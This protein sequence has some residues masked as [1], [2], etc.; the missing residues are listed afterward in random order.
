MARAWWLHVNSAHVPNKAHTS[1]YQNRG[2]WSASQF[3]RCYTFLVRNEVAHLLIDSH[4]LAFILFGA[5]RAYEVPVLYA[6]KCIGMNRW[7][8]GQA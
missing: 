7:S 6:T 3:R 2:W 5:A 1:K 4:I 8:L